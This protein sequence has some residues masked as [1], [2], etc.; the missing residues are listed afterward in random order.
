[1]DT[2]MVV[3]LNANGLPAAEQ[4][5]GGIAAPRRKAASGDAREAE[6]L[7]KQLRELAAEL[8]GVR[9]AARLSLARELHDSVGA[10]LTAARFA[11]AN[12]ALRL[13]A[14][15]GTACA[16]ALAVATR[17]LDAASDATARV[18]ADMHAPGLEGGGVVATLAQWTQ[19]FAERTALRTSFV[20]PADVRLTQL[21]HDAALAVFRAAQEA[22]NNIAKHAGATRADVRIQADAHYLTLIVEDDGCGLTKHARRSRRGFGLA[23]MRA[24]CAAFGGT[25]RLV[26]RNGQPPADAGGKRARTAHGTTVRARFSWTSLLKTAATQGAM[27]SNVAAVR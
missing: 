8:V 2:S 26:S 20:C 4:D 18:V 19:G 27:P 7:R 1:M 15:A 6:R 12:L 22:L 23:G 17:S 9:E 11:L 14:E 24:R 10:E 3:L 16:D 25:L 5:V 21:P 13:P